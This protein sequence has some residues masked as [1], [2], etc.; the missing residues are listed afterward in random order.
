M[1]MIRGSDIYRNQG[2]AAAVEMALMLPMLL[3]L[4]FGSFEAGNFFWNEHIVVKSVRDAARYAGRQ[5]FTSYSCNA[6][7]DVSLEPRIINLARTGQLTGGNPKVSGWQATDVTVE[8]TSDNATT[9]G[10]YQG[11]AC[12]ARRVR[13]IAV[14]DYLSIFETLGV[15]DSS[16]E[17]RAEAQAA[18]MGI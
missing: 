17:L 16:F 15:I 18:V 12:G 2:G 1:T 8:V 9:T 7:T 11:Q 3:L 5:P 10:I 6:V 4:M 14:V 13:V